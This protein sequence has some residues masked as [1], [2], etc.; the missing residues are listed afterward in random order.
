MRAAGKNGIHRHDCEL[1]SYSVRL[2]FLQTRRRSSFS[3]T[4][5]VAA[6]T[7][8]SKV[9]PPLALCSTFTVL[10]AVNQIRRRPA[11][12]SRL[13]PDLATTVTCRKLSL[14]SLDHFRLANFGPWQVQL[15]FLLNVVLRSSRGQPK[16]TVLVYYV[17]ECC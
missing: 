3:S 9:S 15:W 14:A 10:L 11:P 6:T 8:A 16:I 2:L 13:L 7:A 17:W 1:N 12:S 5:T 4:A